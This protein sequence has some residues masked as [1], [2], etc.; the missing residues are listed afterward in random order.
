MTVC[1]WLLRLGANVNRTDI[2]GRTSLHYAAQHD[3]ANAARLLIAAGANLDLRDWKDRTPL[4]IAKTGL[5]I[6]IVEIIRAEES[7][8][9]A[10]RTKA[11][12]LLQTKR[13]PPPSG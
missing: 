1:Q 12:R 9:G 11:L 7:L 13:Q 5:A 3:S 6:D 10:Q 4:I 2:L 8:R